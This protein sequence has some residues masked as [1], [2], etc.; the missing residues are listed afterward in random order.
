MRQSGLPYVDALVTAAELPALA[1]SDAVEEPH[2]HASQPCTTLKSENP[3]FKQL[4]SA[5]LGWEHCTGVMR[6]R[7]ESMLQCL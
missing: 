2:K 5:G 6:C 3:K 7:A 1:N 4:L